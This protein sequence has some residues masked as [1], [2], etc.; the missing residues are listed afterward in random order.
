M[1][2]KKRAFPLVLVLAFVSCHRPATTP[3]VLEKEKF[4]STYIALL[5]RSTHAPGGGIDSTFLRDKAAVFAE[6]GVTEAQYRNTIRSYATRPEDWKD[7]FDEV[8]RR[9]GQQ[10]LEERGKASS[11]LSAL[12]LPAAPSSP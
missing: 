9:L 11:P 5:K 10:I 2:Y 6:E 3:E 7:F 12:T 4:V 1:I 8:V